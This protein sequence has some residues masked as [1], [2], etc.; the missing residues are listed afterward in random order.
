MSGETPNSEKFDVRPFLYRLPGFVLDGLLNASLR[1]KK[2]D[3]EN[4]PIWNTSSFT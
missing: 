3:K 4:G 1:N 2:T